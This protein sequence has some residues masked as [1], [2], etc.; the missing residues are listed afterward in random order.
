MEPALYAAAPTS[1]LP[2]SS[3]EWLLVTRHGE[4]HVL[5]RG[6]LQA[7]DLFGE[8][9]S[10]DE[11]REALFGALPD[12][13][14]QPEQVE[15]VIANLIQRRLLLEAK[16]AFERINRK[17]AAPLAPLR[18]VLLARG[19]SLHKLAEELAQRDDWQDLIVVADGA[20]E[21]TLKV[22]LDRLPD[23]EVKVVHRQALRAQAHDNI[24]ALLDTDINLALW[25]SAGRRLLWLDDLMHLPVRRRTGAAVPVQLTENAM[26][27][28]E[29]FDS[30]AGALESGAAEHFAA[31]SALCGGDLSGLNELHGPWSEQALYGLA[32]GALIGLEHGAR[33][34]ATVAGT[35]GS[36]DGGHSLWL[37]GV[38]TMQ[39]SWASTQERYQRCVEAQALGHGCN[40]TRIMR[41]GAWRPLLIDSGLA[42][43]FAVGSNL[44]AD[45]CFHALSQYFRPDTVVAHLP[46][47]VGRSA[48]LSR[49]RA[50]VNRDPLPPTLNGFV[51]DHA[52]GLA[53]HILA[54]DLAPRAA[55][56]ADSLRDLA[57]ATNE[58]RRSVL[59]DYL[60]VQQGRLLHALQ[61]T[62]ES[63]EGMP[64]YWRKDIIELAHNYGSS[65]MQARTAR[66]HECPAGADQDAAS[67]HFAAS[68]RATAE[69]ICAW[70]ARPL[71]K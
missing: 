20:D 19:R 26:R 29:D 6:V 32:P 63:S 12:L 24:R 47:S 59:W 7:L 14:R 70:T 31:H 60:S 56:L 16:D 71:A 8:F 58:H 57:E 49:A 65:L 46:D 51:A 9:R 62:L 40:E 54:T 34:R 44:H 39:P 50:E 27:T 36:A 43:G 68:L 11:H 21:S 15:R 13:R 55:R 64:E 35:R 2:V 41:T 23:R 67:E 53:E 25:L 30:H 45:R 52:S 18:V 38:Y 61:I 3:E 22:L 66:L 33:I 28:I 17:L 5:A 37:Y 10:L 48:G 42:H 1:R 4:R 69:H